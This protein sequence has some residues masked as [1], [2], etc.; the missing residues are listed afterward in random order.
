MPAAKRTAHD[1]Q[2]FKG[3]KVQR[4]KMPEYGSNR[5]NG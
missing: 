4:Q 3:S 5:L 2:Q 1:V